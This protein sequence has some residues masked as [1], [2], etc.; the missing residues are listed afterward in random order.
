MC[1]KSQ[2]QKE[3]PQAPTLLPRYRKAVTEF[4]VQEM[5]QLRTLLL[6][7]FLNHLPK[8]QEIFPA[9][10]VLLIYTWQLSILTTL[11]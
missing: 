7:Q 4:I 3:M 10:L 5:P 9:G 8:K 2:N 11:R 1:V 6:S